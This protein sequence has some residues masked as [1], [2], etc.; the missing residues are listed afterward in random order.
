MATQYPAQLKGVGGARTGIAPVNLLD[1]LDVNGNAYYWSDRP[2]SAPAVISGFLLPPGV[3]L[4]GEAASGELIAWAFPTVGTGLLASTPRNGAVNANVSQIED[5]GEVSCSYSNFA[6]PAPL[7]P[8]AT[9]TRAIAT[10]ICGGY[11]QNLRPP[12]YQQGSAGIFGPPDGDLGLF[13]TGQ[14]TGEFPTNLSTFA[15]NLAEFSWTVI[16]AMVGPF[17][18]WS[19]FAGVAFVGVCVYYTL[20]GGVSAPWGAGVTPYKP[21][22]VEVPQFTFHRSLITDTG[23]FTLQNLSGDTLSRD[24]EKIARRSALEGALFVYRSWQ[25]DAQAAWLEVHGTLTVPDNGIGVDTVKLKATS[26]LNPSA[27]TAPAEIYCETC[28]QVIWG[29]PGC[30]A[31]GST[32]CQYSFQSCQV[33]ERFKGTMNNYE[34]NYGVNDANTALNVISRRRA[35]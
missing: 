6:L 17:S 8:G 9:V 12:I 20:P 24:F 15:A 10:T 7:P 34:K 14:Y 13:P 29:G 31:T 22:I 18:N 16:T 27:L 5:G 35:I 28:Q 19:A 23:E 3:S 11:I 25:A 21:W 26:L 1:V 33:P 4:P 2:T 32:E 30:G